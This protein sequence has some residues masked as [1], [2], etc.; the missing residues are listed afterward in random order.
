MHAFAT[1]EP[2][3]SALFIAPHYDDVPLSCGGTVAL[4]STLGIRTEILTLFGGEPSGPLSAFARQQHT[5]RGLLDDGSVIALR[6]AEERAAAALLG[7]TASWLDVPDA[8][9]RDARYT[10][11]DDLFGS[12]HPEDLSLLAQLVTEVTH[13]LQAL[14]SPCVVFAPLAIG[15]HVDHQLARQLGLHL[16][17][18]G[19]VVWGYE[20]QP[21]AASETGRATLSVLEREPPGPPWRV[22]LSE[23]LFRRRIDAI[24][25]YRSQIPFVFRALGDAEAVLR[26]Y[27][28]EVGSGSLVE[29]FWPLGHDDSRAVWLGSSV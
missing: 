22:V 19:V 17:Q 7:A 8:I 26:Q 2:P 16:A 12:I 21:Y 29:R 24:R 3:A 10:S 28:L 11:D 4:C 14:P 5:W 25:Q 6:R 1:P 13:R 27:A 9:Y 18:R 15:N 23:E 20:D